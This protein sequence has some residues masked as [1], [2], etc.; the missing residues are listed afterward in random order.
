MQH[1]HGLHADSKKPPRV[2]PDVGGLYHNSQ[3]A[4][5]MTTAQKAS[6]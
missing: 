2:K 1:N 5:K 4:S 6:L 3:L